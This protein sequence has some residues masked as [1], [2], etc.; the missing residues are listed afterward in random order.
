M[1]PDGHVAGAG[2]DAGFE[3]FLEFMSGL[4]REGDREDF[5]RRNLFG[6]DEVRGPLDDDAS[7]PRSCPRETEDLVGFRL[8]G[9][10]LLRIQFNHDILPSP[11]EH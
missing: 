10:S 5:V 11:E 8:D 2:S 9:G 7:L 6:F 4:A 1:V 3:A